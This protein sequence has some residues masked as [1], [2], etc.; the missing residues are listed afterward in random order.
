MLWLDTLQQQIEKRDLDDYDVKVTQ[1]FLESTKFKEFPNV[2]AIILRMVAR[3]HIR[4]VE[5]FWNYCHT[6]DE[7]INK[8]FDGGN[9]MSDAIFYKKYVIV[10]FLIKKKMHANEQCFKNLLY[11][12]ENGEDVDSVWIKLHEHD[13]RFMD[14]K[15]FG[16]TAYDIATERNSHELINYWLRVK[17]QTIIGENKFAQLIATR[18]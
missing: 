6:I 18:V 4:L 2:S 11:M 8:E 14:T 15:F 13:K 16:K 7:T 9:A 1:K 17:R 12:M 5:L 10:D 3:I